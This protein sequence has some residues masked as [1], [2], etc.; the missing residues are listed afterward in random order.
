MVAPDRPVAPLARLHR[1]GATTTRRRSI[2]H[3]PCGWAST[4]SARTSSGRTDRKPRSGSMPMGFLN[5][6][7]VQRRPGDATCTG[8]AKTLAEKGCADLHAENLGRFRSESGD[9]FRAPREFSQDRLPF[10][11]GNWPQ[12][13]RAEALQ[14]TG[15]LSFPRH[16]RRNSAFLRPLSQQRHGH[17]P[18]FR[19]RCS[20]HGAHI[21]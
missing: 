14:W 7:C 1:R 6:W 19:A 17:G 10:I 3:A 13:G 9:G 15:C 16:T 21:P 11:R 18:F 5:W 2:R 4:S 8:R 20:H 12:G